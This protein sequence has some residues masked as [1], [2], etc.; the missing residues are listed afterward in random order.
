MVDIVASDYNTLQQRVA[1]LLGT[2]SATFGYGQTVISSPV[3]QGNTITAAQ[4][5]DLRNDILSVKIHQTGSTPTI[6]NIAVGDLID[7]TSADPKVQYN[8]LLSTAEA[9]RFELA[10]SQ[11]QITA[12]TPK[13]FSSVWSNSAEMT[14]T[15]TF[16]TANEARYFFNSGGAIRIESNRTGGSVSLQNSAWSDLLDIVGSQSFSANPVLAVNFYTLTNNYQTFYQLSSSAPYTSNTYKLQAKCDV[17][18][19]STGTAKVVTVKVLLEDDYVDPDIGSGSPDVYPP[20]DQVDG[21]LTIEST[22]I[23]ASGFLQ[24]TGNFTITSP[25]FTISNITAT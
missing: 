17:A 20:D 12:L 25:S 18:D 21:T 5:D 4:W 22:E 13:T 3:F 9:E 10:V 15:A 2:V 14:I 6:R 7:D 1:K 23:K 11:S 16:S 24:P 8:T 19:N